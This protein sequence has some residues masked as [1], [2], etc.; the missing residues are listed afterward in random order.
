MIQGLAQM[1]LYVVHIRKNDRTVKLIQIEREHIELV[2][3]KGKCPLDH[4]D[5]TTSSY[6][7]ETWITS[8]GKFLHKCNGRIVTDRNPVAK[9]QRNND[10]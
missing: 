1:E 3:G 9:N 7:E 8:L 5:T 4:P 10:E 2:I 6:I